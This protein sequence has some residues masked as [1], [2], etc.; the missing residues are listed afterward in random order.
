M[1]HINDLIFRFGGR[2]IFDHATVA[3]PKGHRVALV[4][5]NGTGKTTL[6]RLIAGQMAPDGGSITMPAETRLGIVAQEAPSSDVSLIDTVLAADVERTALLAEA[7][8]ARDPHRIGEI[9]TRLADIHAHSAPARAAQILSGLGFDAEAQTRPCSDFSGGWRMR[10]ALA[11]VLFAQPELLLLDEPT[12]HLDLEATIW[13]ENYLRN[14]PHTILL[15]SHDR[16]LLNKVPTTTVHLDQGKLVSYAGGY[17]QFERTRRA[18]LERLAANQAKQIAQRKH[19]QSY[20]DRFRYKASKARQAQSRIKMLERMEP[21]I[22]IVEDHTVSFDFPSPEPLA[23]P[24]IQL[25][26]VDVGYDGKPILRGLDLRIDLDDRIA[27]LGAN[28]NGKSTLVKLLASR[29]APMKGEMRKSGKLK[30]GYFAQHQ[31]EEL[32]LNLTAVA[33]ARLWMKDVVD[34]KVRAHLGRFGFPQQ[35][36]DT[37]IAKLSGGE[38]ARLLFALMT[39]DAPHVLMLDEPTNHLDIDSRE[40]LIQAIN[41]FEGAV[42]LISHDPHLIELTADRLWLVDGGACRSYDGDLEDY[43]K[44][45]LERSRADRS[46]GSDRDAGPS[47]KD[48][49]RAAAEL[50]AA[51]APLKRKADDAEKLIAKLT[52]E[53]QALE[54]KLADPALYSGP[55]DKVTKLQIDLGEVQKKLGAA[56]DTWMEALEALE[57]AESEAA[58]AA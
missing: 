54:T 2:V 45:L 34:E 55:A 56:E 46:D 43:R 22:S 7:E 44:L 31:A 47:K 29:L 10:V 1:L 20:I 48:Q 8:T 49:R 15:V 40:A 17:D 33:Q 37:Q 38:K 18:N 30:I 41:G 19:I 32:D 4:G 24:L 26:D 35:K 42:I 25:E 12:N 36:A 13:L 39:R 16:E 57:A 51:L 14:Y 9:H 53:R 50:R 11:G 3:I 23:P 27:L 6:L 5:R 52:R 21:I 58:G 28:G